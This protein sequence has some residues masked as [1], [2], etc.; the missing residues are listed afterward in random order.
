LKERIAMNTWDIEEGENSS[1]KK[2]SRGD[3]VA[4]KKW[5]RKKLSDN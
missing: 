2:Y 1:F 5:L 3:N 4:C